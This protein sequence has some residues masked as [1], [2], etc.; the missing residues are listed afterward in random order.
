MHP[1]HRPGRPR[2]VDHTSVGDGGTNPNRPHISF[3][4]FHNVT[5]YTDSAVS[6]VHVNT[7]KLRHIMC[8]L[9][10][11]GVIPRS[12]KCT[13]IALNTMSDK[14]GINL[15]MLLSYSFLIPTK[16]V[17]THRCTIPRRDP[18]HL[19]NTSM[20]TCNNSRPHPHEGIQY[21]N[22]PQR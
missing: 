1:P 18:I 17:P 13:R 14:H 10:A 12:L 11:T 19:H 6:R 2:G 8:A 20:L 4:L 9:V 21:G 5:C 22:R 15:C 16:Y 3:A 7:T